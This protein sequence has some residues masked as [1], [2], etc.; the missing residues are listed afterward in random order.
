MR[1]LLSGDSADDVLLGET[2]LVAAEE[3]AGG[4]EVVMRRHGVVRGVVQHGTVVEVVVAV[5]GAVVEPVGP[6]AGQDSLVERIVRDRC[7]ESGV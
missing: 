3:V 5:A 4:G 7:V 2:M 1:R 6:R